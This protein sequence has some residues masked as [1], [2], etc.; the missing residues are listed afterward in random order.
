MPPPIRS[1]PASRL[2]PVPSVAQPQPNKTGVQKPVAIRYKA[3]DKEVKKK[4][5]SREAKEVK[6]EEVKEEKKMKGPH[7]VVCYICG[8]EFGTKSLPFHEP[9]CLQVSFCLYSQISI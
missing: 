2:R 5:E 8:R 1:T 6:K 7:T 4:E 9:K 3:R